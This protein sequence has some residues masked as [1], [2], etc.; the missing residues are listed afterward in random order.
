MAERKP[1]LQEELTTNERL[2]LAQLSQHPGFAVLIR[3]IEAECANATQ[4]VIKLDPGTPEY[5]RI[6]ISRQNPARAM[7][8]FA[9]SIRDSVNYHTQEAIAELNNIKKPVEP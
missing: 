6:L 5:D 7:N 4:E 3:F 8:K 1:L 2:M 9:A